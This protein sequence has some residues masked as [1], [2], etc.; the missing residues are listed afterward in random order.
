MIVLSR[1]T[2]IL[3]LLL[4]VST[5][6]AAQAQTLAPV[7][8][9]KMPPSGQ[10]TVPAEGGLTFQMK[11]NGKGPFKTV[12]DTG[13]VNIISANFAAQLGLRVEEKSVDMGCNW[14]ICKSEDC[15]H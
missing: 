14:G 10:V 5:V 2:V 4:A 12:F 6:R 15:P 9:Y 3:L 7:R 1:C 13:A 8:N 11:V